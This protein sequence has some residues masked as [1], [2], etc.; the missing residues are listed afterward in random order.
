MRSTAPLMAVAL[1]CVVAG[2][3]VMA[4]LPGRT[5]HQKCRWKAED[6]FDD[7]QVIALCRAIEASDLAE[8]EGR[9][10]DSPVNGTSARVFRL[11]SDS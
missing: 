7:P 11:T 5:I 9:E 4:M 1:C 10:R 3:G 2:C 8:M 6:Y